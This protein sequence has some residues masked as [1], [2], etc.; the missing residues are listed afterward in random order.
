MLNSRPTMH[1]ILTVS[2][3]GELSGP[4]NVYRVWFANSVR[5]SEGLPFQHSILFVFEVH[6][7]RLPQSLDFVNVL[8]I[9]LEGASDKNKDLV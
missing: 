8:I 2:D 5:L 7:G 4:H 3:F 1:N 6:N 9:W